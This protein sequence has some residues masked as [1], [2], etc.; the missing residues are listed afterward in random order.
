MSGI[1]GQHAAAY[2]DASL[3][4]FPVDTRHKRPAVKGWQGA[5]AGR[6]RK[7]A[8][9]PRLAAADGIGLLMGKPSGITEVDVDAAGRAWTAAAL[10][11]FGET[12]VVIETA[13]GKSKLW[14]RHNGE[15][16]H[17]RPFDG[18]PVDILGDGLT[19]APPSWRDDLGASYRFTRGSLADLDRLPVIGAGAFTRAAE[20][21]QR[22]ERNNTA[23]RYAMAQARHC[24]D[25]EALLD[26]VVTYAEAMPEPL[27]AGEIERL[28]ASAWGYEAAGK[29]Y[30]GLRKPLVTDDDKT[31]G[32]LLDAPD[33]FTL[34]SMFRMWHSGRDTFA[35]A[36]RAM[37]DAGSP[38]WPRRR[39]AAARDVLIE[40]GY[41]RE[42]QP[43]DR[44]RHKAGQYRLS[45]NAQNWAQS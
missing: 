2:A 8:E 36:P 18:L 34:L 7:W 33:A 3:P 5:T 9:V 25:L 20:G 13:S 42:V 15:G 6:S 22:G 16:R 40:R 10:E 37:S 41:L 19:I 44:G 32:A 26:V 12:P 14:Y 27:P 28:V 35:I 17:I 21:V 11:R 38:P 30:L 1:Y 45:D 23:W 31:L 29:N 4:V 43:P 39:I 24:D